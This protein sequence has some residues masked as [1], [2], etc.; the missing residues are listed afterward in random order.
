MAAA[1]MNAEALVSYYKTLV[2]ISHMVSKNNRKKFNA[3]RQA[4][5]VRAE[6]LDVKL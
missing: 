3:D 5:Y 4:V 2:S 6:E 1:T